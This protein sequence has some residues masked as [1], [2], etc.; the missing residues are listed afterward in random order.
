MSSAQIPVFLSYSLIARRR[1]KIL[2]SIPKKIGICRMVEIRALSKD[3]SSF[4]IAQP[5][6]RIPFSGG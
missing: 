3:F 2:V 6:T 1:V 5:P 4:K